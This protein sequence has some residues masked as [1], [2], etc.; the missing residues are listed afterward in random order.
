MTV[1]DRET[2]IWRNHID[3][4]RSDLFAFSHLRNWNRTGDLENLSQSALMFRRHVQN[5]DV[6]HPAVFSYPRET[7][8][9]CLNPA[10]RG[11]Q[12]DNQELIVQFKSRLLLGFWFFEILFV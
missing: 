7:L 3:V 11:P 4:V 12:T 5:Y 10:S 1:C 2:L 6:S 8:L 9:Q